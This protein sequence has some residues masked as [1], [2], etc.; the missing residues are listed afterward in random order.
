ML[1]N[2][3]SAPCAI[4]CSAMVNADDSAH[5]DDLRNEL[6]YASTEQ[7][8]RDKLILL[9]ELKSAC[10]DAEAERLSKEKP[11][12]W[13]GQASIDRRLHPLR[14]QD[15]ASLLHERDMVPVLRTNMSLRLCIECAKTETPGI[16]AQLEASQSYAS[17]SLIQSCAHVPLTIMKG[18]Q[19]KTGHALLPRSV[20]KEKDQRIQMPRRL[21]I[22][23]RNQKLGAAPSQ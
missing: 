12:D 21:L 5:L 10:V 4:C 3:C 1:H 8:K 6:K 15:G 18:A 17:T 9:D 2:S 7:T 16:L 11:C 19:L 23:S 14:H 13:C 20:A 22:R